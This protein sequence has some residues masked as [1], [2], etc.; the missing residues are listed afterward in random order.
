MQTRS[1]S[2]SFVLRH[3][4]NFTGESQWSGEKGYIVC[5]CLEWILVCFVKIHRIWE[6][7]AIL[8]CLSVTLLQFFS[9]WLQVHE[10]QRRYFRLSEMMWRDTLW[11]TDVFSKK[12]KMLMWELNPP[13]WL[14]ITVLFAWQFHLV[15]E[16]CEYRAL[17]GN[18]RQSWL[19]E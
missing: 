3:I 11:V 19:L 18:H 14:R 4:C 2:L 5:E 7:D 15:L 10:E 6:A 1:S 16:S 12:P 9:V 8:G 13:P 17:H